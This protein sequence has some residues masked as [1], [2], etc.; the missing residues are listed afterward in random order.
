MIDDK[1][2]SDKT[3]VLLETRFAHVGKA[4]ASSAGKSKL[5]TVVA[6]HCV[7]SLAVAVTQCCPLQRSRCGAQRRLDQVRCRSHDEAVQ[8]VCRGSSRGDDG[9]GALC[10]AAA[11]TAA[12]TPVSAGT[13]CGT[14]AA[15]AVSCRC[16]CPCC[17]TPC[18]QQHPPSHL[19]HSGRWR[20]PAAH[21]VIVEPA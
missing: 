12:S 21:C 19:A 14:A 10:T 20:D 5:G 11:A 1:N 13:D 16:R 6:L 3:R 18:R 4:S 17:L 2:L 15:A 9:A 7:C 8:A